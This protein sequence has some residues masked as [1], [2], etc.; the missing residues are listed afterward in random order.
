MRK[1]F[2]IIVLSLFVISA[3]GQNSGAL[4]FLGIPIDGPKA[5]FVAALKAK[6]FYYSSVSERYKGQFNGKDVDVYVHT[7][8]N[9]VDRVYVAFPSTTEEGIRTEFN[10]LLEQFQNTGKYLAFA[11]NEMIPAEEDISYEITVNNKRYQASFC[12]FDPE[13]D[14]VAFMSAFLDKFSEFFT[15][16][17]VTKLK[18]FA[19]RL[20]D[21]PV[22]QMDALQAEMLAEM[23]MMG[24]GQDENAGPDPEKALKFMIAFMDGASSLADGSVWFMIHHHYGRYNIG[25]YYD[26]L[27]NQA[28]GED[29]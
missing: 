22:E 3:Y 5:Q 9:L 21:V 19:M 11:V 17:Q 26:N 15:E 16:E 23:Q 1:V 7:N 27:H 4:K 8:H 6:G 10:R 13:R 24:Y 28:H 20:V 14:P 12:Y 25:L 2:Y 29:L 18:E